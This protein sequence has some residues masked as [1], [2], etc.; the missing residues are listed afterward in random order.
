MDIKLILIATSLVVFECADAL[1]CQEGK[2]IL[3]TTQVLF[4]FNQIQGLDTK[5]VW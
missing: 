3:Q 5:G 4:R 2:L 1:K